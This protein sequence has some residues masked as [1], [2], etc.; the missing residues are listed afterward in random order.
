MSR[1]SSR[2]GNLEKRHRPAKEMLGSHEVHSIGGWG[3]VEGERCF[4]HEDCVFQ[5]FPVQGRIRRVI[6]GRWDDGM[7]NLLE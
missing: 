1:L 2:L 7:T 4:E 5:S 3:N 6:M